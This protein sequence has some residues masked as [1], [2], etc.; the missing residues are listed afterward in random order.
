LGA[1][2]NDFTIPK[3]T[4][5]DSLLELGRRTK[6]PLAIPCADAAFQ[7]SMISVHLEHST[8]G[9]VLSAILRDEPNVTAHLDQGVIVVDRLP[10]ELNC[11]F[12]D[13]VIPTFGMTHPETVEHISAKLWMTLELQLDPTKTGFAGILHPSDYDKKLAP[14]ELRNQTVGDILTWLVARHS[15]AAWIG[16]PSARP[17]DAYL[18]ELW[19]IVFYPTE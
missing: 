16:L 13:T 11:K 7:H 18:N 4:I 17:S 10:R 1:P 8:V 15:A 5:V 19:R 6:I 14:F 9:A 2:V 3:S 12:I